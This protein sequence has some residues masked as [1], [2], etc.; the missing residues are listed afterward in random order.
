[1]GE[2]KVAE[3]TRPSRRG[4]KQIY[5]QQIPASK[6]QQPTL[7]QDLV[8]LV[9]KGKMYYTTFWKGNKKNNIAK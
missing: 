8:L 2:W 3:A 7:G 5:Y 6:S 1:L 4:A 9:H